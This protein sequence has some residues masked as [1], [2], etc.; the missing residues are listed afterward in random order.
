MIAEL[1]T[2]EWWEMLSYIV[3]VVALPQA[4]WLY[5]RD[6]TRERENEEE[7]VYLQLSDAY[8][9]FSNVLLENA[10]L[11]LVGGS[12]P[13]NALTAEQRERKKI[14]YEMLVSL[15]ERAFILVYEDDMDK[16]ARRRWASWED[17]IKFWLTRDDFRTI[18][19]ELLKGEDEDF[20]DY[21][22]KIAS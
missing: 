6:Q 3:T 4:I 22:N 5:F 1:T 19:P 10:D 15:F 9:K 2:L 12:L 13:D 7:E 20:I 17:Y 14:I 8:D 11:Q 18:L 21:M 16:Q